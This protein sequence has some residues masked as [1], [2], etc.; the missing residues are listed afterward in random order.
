MPHTAGLLLRVGM[1]LAVISAVVAGDLILGD[2]IIFGVL[3]AVPLLVAQVEGPKRVLVWGALCVVLEALLGIVDN[4]YADG[5]A[6]SAQAF[7]LGFVV[8]TTAAGAG[9]AHRRL[10]EEQH[11]R[12]ITAVAKAAQRAI[13]RPLPRTI[14]SWEVG[15]D[16]TG[17]Y[18]ESRVGGDLYDAQITDAGLLVIVGDT[19]GKGLEAVRLAAL[20]LGTFRHP[21]SR[22]ADPA[23][24][25]AAMHDTV[26]QHG[27]DEDFVTAVL[28]EITREGRCRIWNAGHPP[29]LVVRGGAATPVE[30]AAPVPPLGL[31]GKAHPS[32]IG[33]SP[34]DVLLLYTD[35][36]S[37]ARRPSDRAFFPLLEAAGG[38]VGGGDLTTAVVAL[39][40]QA[41]AW[42]GGALGDDVA[43]L[44]VRQP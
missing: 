44:A 11:L 3:S 37:E 40:D 4:T 39:R 22:T 25:Y 15:Y 12:R 35:G 10:Q 24:V 8:L 7:R 6:A 2:E 33:L 26:Q 34:G 32:E 21:S 38:T 41:T 42:T 14:G 20:V 16:Y 5:D 31:G 30:A 1:P 28:A 27:G 36:L 29:P 13:L 18:Q 9:L 19:R 17:A 43:L 23:D